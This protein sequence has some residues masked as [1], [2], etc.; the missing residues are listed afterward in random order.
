MSVRASSALSKSLHAITMRAP[1]K[2]GPKNCDDV[3]FPPHFRLI[4]LL[5]SAAQVELELYTASSL[6]VCAP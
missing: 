6:F 4:F 5:Q 2:Q 3:T 1:E